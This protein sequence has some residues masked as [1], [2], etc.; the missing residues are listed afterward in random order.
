MGPKKSKKGKKGDD[1]GA[2]SKNDGS[3]NSPDKEALDKLS[4]RL[5]QI[6]TCLRDKVELESRRQRDDT[7]ESVKGLSNMIDDFR[8]DFKILRE[9]QTQLKREISQVKKAVTCIADKKRMD[10]DPCLA[11][12]YSQ[13]DLELE[14]NSRNTPCP[15]SNSRNTRC[16]AEASDD[17]SKVNQCLI[18]AVKK[19]TGHDITK[20][21]IDYG[22][23]ENCGK[24][25]VASKIRKVCK[26]GPFPAH[27]VND[28]Q[29]IK[30]EKTYN[31]G[32]T[33]Q[34]FRSL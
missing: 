23:Q 5:E 12:D 7:R 31:F 15:E 17:M 22:N 3:T 11:P 1:G 26:K 32:L 30:N 34:L 6:D 16:P 27:Q 33:D 4:A 19:L 28:E 29:Q 9:D 10:S 18:E 25:D 20:I 21:I 8:K 24:K 13:T 2:P 14:S